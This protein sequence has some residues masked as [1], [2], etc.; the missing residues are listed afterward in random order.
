MKKDFWIPLI[1]S[2]I[3]GFVSAQIVYSTYRKNL[4]SIEY[5]AYFLMIDNNDESTE[6]VFSNEFN[7]LSIDNSVYVGITTSLNNAHKIKNIYDNNNI[8]VEIVPSIIDNVEFISNLE[9]YDI[10][11]SEVSLDENII[12]ISDAVLSSYEEIVL[13]N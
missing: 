7:Y 6:T 12:S 13:G 3:L 11:I 9:Q 2:I 4:D 1:V 5:N 10:L 8:K